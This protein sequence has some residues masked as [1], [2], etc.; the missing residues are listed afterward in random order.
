MNRVS[1]LSHLRILELSNGVAGEFCGK[2]LADFG[3][4]IRK[5]ECPGTGSDTRRRGPFAAR[6]ASHERSGLFAYLNTNKRSV[7]LDVSTSRGK[8]ALHTLVREV[9]A[10][11]DDHPPGYLESLG[12]GP[13]D[14]LSRY[15]ELMLCTITPFGY[16]APV[17][18][19]KSYSLN[20]FHSSGW[21]YHSPSE[22]DLDKPPLK[23]AGRFHVDYESGLSA[24]LALAAALYWR[25]RSGRGQFLDVSQQE[26]MATLSDYVLG[27]MVA[28][29]MEVSTRRQAFDLRGPATFFQCQDGYVYL[30]M[31]EPGHWNG[32]SSLMGDPAWMVDFPQRWLELHLTEERI[33]RC[34]THIAQWMKDQRRL[35]VAT[36]AQ[37]LGVPLVAVNTAKDLFESEQMQFRGFFAQVD[38]PVLGRLP[39]PTVPYRLSDTPARIERPAPLLGQHTEEILRAAASRSAVAPPSTATSATAA[40][41]PM[42][43]GSPGQARTGP[44][45]GVR[46][47][48][49]TKI[50]AGPYTGKLLAL[51]GAEVIRVESY[52]S[53]DATRRYGVQDINAAPGFQAINPGK[54]SV[55]LNVRTDKG[56]HLVQELV[57]SSDIFIENLRPGAATRLGLGYEVLRSLRPDIV[58]VSMSMYGHEGPLSY[59]TGYAPCFSALAGVCQLVGYENGPPQLLNIRYGDSS[60][61][62]AAAFAAVVALCHRHRTGQ[63]Q[64]V[65][66]SAV[67]SLAAMLGDSFMEYSLTARVPTRDGNRHPEMAPHGCYPCVGDEWISI[68]VQTDQEWRALCEAMGQPSLAADSRY[69]DCGGRQANVRELDEQLAAWTRTQHAQE[70]ASALRGHGIAAFK[71]LSSIDLISDGHLWERGFY[72]HVTDGRHRS[73]PI[74]GAPWR[75]SATPASIRC[76]APTL[77]EHNDY[78]LGELLGLS[79]AERG[80]LRAEKIVY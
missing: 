28:G 69:A 38:H 2:L 71:S 42:R 33:Q 34:R 13:T 67:E 24:A 80:R 8:E 54:Y 32:L 11:V 66:V 26:S 53:L 70:L 23:G 65:D 57:R 6:G 21:G 77:G 47:L 16:D 19:Q 50:W 78:V 40:A 59:Q 62:T 74:V 61:G 63:G 20:V 36:R 18:M 39:Y 27:Q 64:F 46:V 22:P 29:N 5:L 60:Y 56:R 79:A 17:T 31:S 25:G 52:D 7:C 72:T 76:A 1:A 49:L 12:I 44:L 14:V 30:W 55:Q 9:D 4:D 10:V 48:E 41:S 73:I 51:L 15:P 35:E 43:A 37:K 75:M 45:Q 68:A 58:A 3:A